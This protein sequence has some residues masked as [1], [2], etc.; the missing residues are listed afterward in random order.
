MFLKRIE[1]LGF[2][3]FADK[4]IIDF[5]DGITALLGPNGCGKSNIVDAVKWVL[6]E[7][8]VRNMR[9]ERMDDVIFSGTEHRKALSAAEVTLVIANETGV[10]ELERPEIAIK[11]RIFREG[12]N[13]YI[14]NGNSVRLKEIR[15]LF[16]DTGIGKSAYSIMEQG[17]IDQI[18]STRPEERRYLF[19]EAAGIT[20]F[21]A[22]SNEAERK[23][24]RTEENMNQVENILREVRRSHEVLKKQTEKTMA[25]R[26]LREEIFTLD[27][28][29]KLQQWQKLEDTR[30]ERTRQLEN[31]A[32]QYTEIARRIQEIKNTLASK[33]DTVN[34]ME[35]R[36]IENQKQLY[37]LDLEKE[38]LQRQIRQIRDNRNESEEILKTF[39]AREKNAA[40]SLKE[41]AEQKARRE[42]D[43]V[44]FQ[45]RIKEIE[46]SIIS[47][48]GTIKSS[49]SRIQQIS[50]DTESSNAALIKEEKLREGLQDDLRTLT[51]DIVRELEK[52]LSDSDRSTRRKLKDRIN[53]GINELR[54]RL[55]GRLS[56]F[57]DRRNLAGGGK[58]REI[59]EQTAVYFD[60][61]SAE[62]EALA[63]FIEEYWASGA[64]FLEEFL[65]PEG[66]ITRKRE[67]DDKISTSKEK[68]ASLKE[69]ILALGE[70]KSSLSQQIQKFR[71]SMEEFRVAQARTTT[72][73]AAVRD[74]LASLA[75]ETETEEK[76][77]DEIR[78]QI[79]AENHKIKNFIQQVD[80]LIQKQ[81]EFTKQQEKLRGDMVGLESG[82]S[83]ENK[84]MAG[85]EEE[86][87]SLSSKRGALELEKEKIRMELGYLS[88]EEKQLLEDFRDRHSRELADFADIKG[89][90]TRAARDIREELA[91]VKGELKALGQV[92]L[93]APEEFVEVA[94]RYEFLNGQLTDLQKGKN[95]LVQVTE[96]IR[97]ESVAKF[98]QTYQDIRHNFHLVFRRLFGGGKAEIR[99]QNSEDPLNSGV[100]ILAQPPGK[101]L[102]NISLLSGGERSLCGVALLFA[103]FMVK[104]SPFCILDEIDAALDEANI[105]RFI[106]ILTEFGQ[107][108][109]FVVITHN[110]K[111]AAGAGSLLGVTMQESGV[112]RLITLKLDEKEQNSNDE[113]PLKAN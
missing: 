59:L 76:H 84:K 81:D 2:K 94:E 89:S 85:R 56:L 82:I 92:N 45:D 65:T 73:A 31:K 68:T 41:L 27:R 15:E 13:E 60:E 25:Y 109:Q 36:L 40:A 96:E 10:L 104:P 70:E 19:E 8:S 86:L 75:R 90:I 53:S 74:A 52:H 77:L 64:D 113:K 35:S 88:E 20:K 99:L 38:N 98:I 66:I 34:T 57:G 44:N 87:Q 30:D 47:C 9:A 97:R 1:I 46:A 61:L 12:E 100:E 51:D 50:T 22:R 39:G 106:G 3:S 33:L 101:K 11:R 6:G 63:G 23:L 72:Q 110:K 17:R 83:R 93:M 26:R 29:L 67:L 62:I 7:Q 54:I 108:S 55:K 80:L 79:V 14:L 112:S 37:G 95:D 28:N 48:A 91:K 78:Q 71:E 16:F 58:S 42:V 21:L 105:Q 18:L 32:K 43:L 103:T 5:S 69:R 24:T 4:T 102:E 107:K 49:E 111:T